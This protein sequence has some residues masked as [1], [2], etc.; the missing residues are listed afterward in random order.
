MAKYFG[1]DGRPCQRSEWSRLRS[2]RDYRIIKEYDNGQVYVRLEWLG[3]VADPSTFRDCWKMFALCVGNYNA[4]GD[5]KEDPVENGK[6]F[7]YE[8]DGIAAYEAFL[9]RWTASH[10][11]ADGEFEEEDNTLT[12]TPPPPPDPDAPST[13]ASTVESVKLG[14]DDVGVW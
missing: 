6:T 11:N 13:D 2:D 3:E 1:R 4:N 14:E 7:A 5:I 8:K 9:E 12:L 10:R